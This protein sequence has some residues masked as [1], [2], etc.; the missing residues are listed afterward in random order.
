MTANVR[1]LAFDLGFRWMI[2]FL[3]LLALAS[4]YLY[5]SEN[6]L[7]TAMNGGLMF[8]LLGNGARGKIALWCTLPVTDREIGRARWW[9][10][11]GLPG[12][13]IV[14]AMGAALALHA[15]MSAMG[16]T[17]LPI[18]V[19]AGGTSRGL[20]LQ[21]FYPVFLTVFSLAI[22]FARA[23]RSP[24]AYAATVLVWAPWLLLFP[25]VTLL[26][27]AQDRFLLLGLIGVATAVI[28][29]ATARHWPLPATQP[30]QLDLGG[31]GNRA[32]LRARAGQGGWMLLCGMELVRPLLVLVPIM[33]LYIA[34]ILVLNL[35]HIVP[36]QM[37]MFIPF[38]VIS[39]ITRF[40]GTAMRVLRALP[41]SAVALSAY[42]FLL[43][44]A[45]LAAIA[46][47]YSLV[48]EP[49]LT[50]D[51]PQFDI[52]TLSAVL[53]ISALALPAALAVSQTA[54]SLILVASMVLMVLIPFGWQYVPSPWNDEWLFAGLTLMMI[55]IGFFW[56]RAQISRGT[57]VY[58]LQP[59]VAARWRGRD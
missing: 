26:L 23:S 9:Q 37:Q 42:L 7:S 33:A 59:F 36:V 53:F 24:S 52:V 27:P 12:I 51:A 28:L 20:L 31:S 49:W 8:A 43:P 19:D 55:G 39:Q 5:L 21:F 4:D 16:W 44:L 46:V 54:M 48:L 47:P 15:M 6:Q 45:L 22:N 3:I 11:T 10:T 14:V 18:R 40:N 1:N 2:P 35:R 29:Y 25:N 38:I 13:G 32:N 58:R 41:G 34:A 57:R 17:H 50:G 30:V 56:M